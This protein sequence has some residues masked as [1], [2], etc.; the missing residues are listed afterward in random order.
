M[1]DSHLSESPHAEL[2]IVGTGMAGI[3]LARALRRQGDSR[4]IALVS[5]D[6]GE[7]YS[8]PLLSTGFAKRLS[9]EKLAQRSAEALA[10]ELNAQV[11][12]HTQVVE[13][14]VEHQMLRLGNGTLLRYENLVL[15][16][17]AAPRTPFQIPD[18]LEGRCFTVNDLDDYRRL[19]AAL[20]QPSRVAIIGAGLVGC[21][22]ANDLHAGGHHVTLVAP[23]S[24]LLPRLLPEPL[25]HALAETFRTADM[26]LALGRTLD[27][28]SLNADRDLVLQLDGGERHTVDIVLLATG[29]APR[30]AL[31]EAAGLEVSARGIEVDRLLRTRQPNVYA[32]GDVACIDGVN[33]MYVQPLQVSAKALAAT[34]GGSPTPV[35]FGAWPIIVKTPLLPVVAYPPVSTPQHWRVEGHGQDLTALAEDKDGRLIGFALTGGCVRRKVELSRAVPALLG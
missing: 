28:L 23:E 13:L 20:A 4:T 8:K 12:A 34:L 18:A 29:L 22:F 11:M 6:R 7:E 25:G 26:Q 14:V 10:D 2:V 35:S 19:H 24:T 1:P 15:A 32:L 31:A 5:A 16:T 9:P 33:A 17:G 27:S 3:G 21:E 30:T